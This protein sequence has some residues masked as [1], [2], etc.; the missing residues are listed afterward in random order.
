MANAQCHSLGIL[1]YFILLC[2]FGHIERYMEFISL[3]VCWV[4]V[5]VVRQLACS[6]A[7]FMIFPFS[8][9]GTIATFF[10]ITQPGSSTVLTLYYIYSVVDPH[11]FHCRSGSSFLSQCGSRS[12]YVVLLN[13][14]FS[15]GGD[16]MTCYLIFFLL[17]S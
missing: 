5:D 3:G 8:L 7:E 1:F 13:I 9:N 4:S 11:W 15:H 17:A 10:Q 2:W 16:L 12:I 14:S 6:G